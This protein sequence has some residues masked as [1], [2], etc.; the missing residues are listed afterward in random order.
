MGY[1]GRF[2][3]LGST[4]SE[5]HCKSRDFSRDLASPPTANREGKVLERCTVYYSS[6]RA[7]GGEIGVGD[8]VP[9]WSGWK[10]T[11]FF[12]FFFEGEE[13]GKPKS[14]VSAAITMPRGLT[15]STLMKPFVVLALPGMY[16]FYKYN[17]YRR[18]QQ[19]QNRRKVTER[20]LAHLNH[21]IE[22][23]HGTVGEVKWVIALLPPDL[24]SS[25]FVV[26][27]TLKFSDY[28]LL[29]LSSHSVTL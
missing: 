14:Q 24:T 19:E 15:S 21:K 26:E 22:R 28:R 18:Q 5:P 6:S 17:Q 20:E 10:E 23:I 16:L 11:F 29:E 4:T 27:R 2:N 3:A 12:F 7:V 9:S 8:M 1:L 13:K 25:L